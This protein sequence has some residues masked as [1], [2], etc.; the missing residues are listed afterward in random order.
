[1]ANKLTFNSF[2]EIYLGN[3][4]FK[5]ND[6]SLVAHQKELCGPLVGRGPPVEKHWFTE[7]VRPSLKPIKKIKELIST[8]AVVIGYFLVQC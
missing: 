2:Y 5:Q 1:V 3:Y 4:A 6:E 7:L 8:L